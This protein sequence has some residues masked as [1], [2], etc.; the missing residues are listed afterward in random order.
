MCGWFP[1]KCTYDGISLYPERGRWIV[2]DQS[3]GALLLARM[4]IRITHCWGDAYSKECS[5]VREPGRS[6]SNTCRGHSGQ[7]SQDNRCSAVGKVKLCLPIWMI[8][9]VFKR[10][11]VSPCAKAGHT[12]GM[13]EGTWSWKKGKR[14]VELQPHLFSL[15]SLVNA[16]LFLFQLYWGIIDK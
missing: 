11:W 4:G 15:P 8:S 6:G 1:L 16:C 2:F 14:G 12:L 13:V 10:S 3:P 5:K 7:S 9:G